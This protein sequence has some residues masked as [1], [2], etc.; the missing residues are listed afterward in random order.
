[1]NLDYQKEYWL[2]FAAS[3]DKDAVSIDLHGSWQKDEKKYKDHSI[4]DQPALEILQANTEMSAVL[5]FG[6]GMGRNSEYLATQ[7]K[8]VFGYDTPP[9]IENLGKFRGSFSNITSNWDDAQK[10]RYSLVLDSTVMQ[11]MP[12][13]EVVHRLYCI[14]YM[15]PYLFSIT[16]SYNDFLRDFQN[17]K[18]GVNMA[19]LVDSLD[20]F[21]PVWSSEPLEKMKKKFDETHYS[22]L[23]K[24]KN[25][26]L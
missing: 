26:Q 9:M 19:S 13:Q 8:E 24:S 3:E 12:P 4:I 1:M 14:S 17:Q 5:D 22:V 11:H 10:I 15:S 21:E 25:F 20:A 6:I 2:N 7:F 18:R 23:Y 16:R